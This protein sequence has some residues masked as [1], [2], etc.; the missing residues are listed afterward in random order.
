MATGIRNPS[1]RPIAWMEH[2][3]QTKVPILYY[4]RVAEGVSPRLGVSPAAFRRQLEYLRKRGFTSVS[5]ENLQDHLTSGCP[6]PRNP[7]ILSFDDGYADVYTRAFPI[8][9]SVGFTATVFLVSEYIGL[10]SEWEG[11]EAGNPPLLTRD[12][13]REMAAEGFRFG[14]HS[15]THRSLVS[16]SSEAVK[17]EVEKSRGDLED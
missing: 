14:S 17:D 6:L 12:Q 10:R 16:L 3:F 5:F 11:C 8:L 1:H 9:K 15:R 7:V 4:H 13:I 2:F